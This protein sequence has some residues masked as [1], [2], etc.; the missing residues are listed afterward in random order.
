MIKKNEEIIE[1]GTK[2]LK[3]FGWYGIAMVEFKI[4][5]RD[6]RPKLMEINP[7]FWGSLNLAVASGV[8]FPYL[9]CKM[10]MDGDIDL[11]LEYKTGIKSRWLFYG[12]IKYLIAVLKGYST[13]WGYNSP[14]R[15]QTI[16]DFMKF[17]E[18]DTA[19]DFLSWDDPVPGIMKIFAPVLKK[20]YQ[21]DL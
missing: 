5:P 1:L 9:L 17:Y 13:P 10:A 2:L 18:R 6:N 4:D 7:R 20:L 19:Y 11:R 14:G 3:A 16:L 12:D 21:S 8:D 15:K